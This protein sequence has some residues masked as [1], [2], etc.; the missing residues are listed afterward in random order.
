MQYGNLSNSQFV[1]DIELV[2]N[3]PVGVQ[4]ITGRFGEEKAIAVAKVIKELISSST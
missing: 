4:I 2:K 1:D 3:M